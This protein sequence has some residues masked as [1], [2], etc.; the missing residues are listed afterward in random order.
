[1]GVFLKKENRD[2][3]G[4]AYSA[5]ASESN[6][7]YLGKGFPALHDVRDNI[8][9]LSHGNAFLCE[10]VFLAKTGKTVRMQVDNLRQEIVALKLRFPGKFAEDVDTDSIIKDLGAHAERLQNP[11][12]AVIDEYTTGSLGRGMEETLDALTGAV[13][14]IKRRV[15]GETPPYTARDSVLG[16]IDKAKTPVS[17]VKRL[18]SLTIRTILVLALLSLGPLTYLAVTMDRE[19]AL[20]KEIAESE[21]AIHSQKETVAVLE[22][23]REA[24]VQRIDEMKADDVPRETK[25]E[26]MEMNVK[27]HS[28]DQNRHR[29]E[30]EIS[31]HEERIRINK[32]RLRDVKEKPFLD[33]LLRR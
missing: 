16:V 15:E 29:A 19:G 12:K 30:A 31:A 8:L 26:I 4:S 5:G 32:Q 7:D 33:R 1:M 11:D 28:L 20:L 2:N 10:E 9:L 27:A 25:F 22:R 23:E 3:P 21:A 18:V 13:R 17:M 14:S 6:L 24:L